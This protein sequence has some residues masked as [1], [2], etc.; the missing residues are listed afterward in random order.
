MAKR[1]KRTSK[2]RAQKRGGKKIAR[3]KPAAKAKPARRQRPRAMPA[4]AA[5]APAARPVRSGDD[6]LARALAQAPVVL[7]NGRWSAGMNADG[8]VGI[9]VDGVLDGEHMRGAVT[10]TVRGGRI[11]EARG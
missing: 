8:T 7:D 11:V 2:P 5:P 6:P 4:A 3:H 1:T 9:P 10:V